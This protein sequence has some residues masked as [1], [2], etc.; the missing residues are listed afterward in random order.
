MKGGLD[1]GAVLDE[2]THTDAGRLKFAMGD[3]VPN[4]IV[5]D[6]QRKGASASRL[7]VKNES[8]TFLET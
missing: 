1:N 7:P 4:A 5:L 8:G 3:L 6:D 2:S